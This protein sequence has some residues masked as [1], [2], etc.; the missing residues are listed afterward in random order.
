MTYVSAPPPHDALANTARWAKTTTLALTGLVAAFC[1]WAAMARVEEV[2]RGEG[3]VIPASRIQIV[4]NLE[5][6]IVRHIGTREGAV[7]NAG[8]VIIN[9]D[10]T[11]AGSSFEERREKLIG[12]RAIVARLS[13]QA[14]GTELAI[15]DD[16]LRDRP[17]LA[18][19]QQALYHNRIREIE[20]AL[21]AFDLQASQ[22]RQEIIE[23]K[24]KIQ[25]L[26]KSVQIAQNEIDLTRP[27]VQRGA[28][29]RIELI[30]LEARLNET[31]GAL[32]AATLALPRIEQALAEVITKRREKEL[33]EKADVRQQLAEARVQTSSL[34]Q[35]IKGDADRVE[36]ADVRAPVTGL[37]KT[38]HVSTLGQVIKPGMDIVEIVPTD[39]ALIV[40]ARVRPQ[41]IAFLRPDLDAV[42]RLSA[43]D[44]TLYGTLKA[45]VEHIG[46]DSVTSEKGETYYLVRARTDRAQLQKDGKPLPILPGMVASMDILTGEKTV[47]SYL[48]RPLSRMRN[49]A[50]RER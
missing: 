20:A 11:G 41:D 42:V 6:G 49:E 25:N 47:L 19:E 30:R 32:E 50:L 43:Y 7:V 40:E 4:Q 45:K 8:D 10:T 48:L 28:A 46:A 35:S 18:H 1:G 34:E 23:V 12:L 13:A 22:R 29:A 21:A 38:L 2:T 3:K 36:R 15:P 27:L 14:E 16:I 24:A 39:S 9:I 37:V 33:N 31:S 26:T 44:Y 17:K 5:G